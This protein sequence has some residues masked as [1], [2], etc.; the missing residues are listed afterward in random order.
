MRLLRLKL[1]VSEVTALS[2]MHYGGLI[3]WL[4]STLTSFAAVIVALVNM[5]LNDEAAERRESVALRFREG[6]CRFVAQ[7]LPN[8]SVLLPK[9]SSSHRRSAGAD[10]V[11]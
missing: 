8:K 1:P 3:I 2:D 4:P 10:S 9:R 6:R 5:C 11:A 7:R